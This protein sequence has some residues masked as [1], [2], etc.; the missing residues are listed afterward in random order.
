MTIPSGAA[1]INPDLKFSV[2]GNN[3]T[4]SGLK[5]RTRQAVTEQLRN[6]KYP[7]SSPPNW[8]GK[9]VAAGQV[10]GI[11]ASKVTTGTF[12]DSQVPGIGMLRDAIYQAVTGT[13][14][15]GATSPQVKTAIANW[16]TAIEAR[17]TALET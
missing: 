15:T 3:G 7:N 1:A 8:A 13:G 5:N 9:K 11:D 10:E 6:E 16:K 14:G 2:S 17:L 4:I 12:T